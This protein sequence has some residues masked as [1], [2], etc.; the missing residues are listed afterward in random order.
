VMNVEKYRVNKE[1]KKRTGDRFDY[2]VIF[3]SLDAS[4]GGL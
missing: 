4:Y 1:E 2:T 3:C